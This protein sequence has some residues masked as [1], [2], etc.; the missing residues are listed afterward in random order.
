MNYFLAKIFLS[1]PKTVWPKKENVGAPTLEDIKELTEELSH[2]VPEENKC[3]CTWCDFC[4]FCK[5]CK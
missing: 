5:C 1:K 2:E 4:I 3:K